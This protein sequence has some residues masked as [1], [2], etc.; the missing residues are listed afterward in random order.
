MPEHGLRF[1]SRGRR[2]HLDSHLELLLHRRELLAELQEHQDAVRELRRLALEAGLG[3]EAVGE[4]QAAG[5]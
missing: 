5:P 1:R 2:H 3:E 4:A